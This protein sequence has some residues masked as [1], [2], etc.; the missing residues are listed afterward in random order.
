MTEEALKDLLTRRL[1]GRRV[2]AVEVYRE[3]ERG[4]AGCVVY[5][6]QLTITLDDGTVLDSCGEEMRVDLAE[7]SIL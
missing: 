2:A 7:E 3:I 6:S 5:Y 1:V 4:T